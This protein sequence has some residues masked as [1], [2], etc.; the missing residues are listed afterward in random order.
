VARQQDID[1]KRWEIERKRRA[2]EA[3]I[4]ALKTEFAAEEKGLERDL[5]QFQ[6]LQTQVDVNRAQ[7]ARSRGADGRAAKTGGR[8]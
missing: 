6:K 8:K 4:D 3:Q 7:M 2:L 5:E 1:R